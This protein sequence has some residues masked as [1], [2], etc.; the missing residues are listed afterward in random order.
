[1]RVLVTGSSGFVGRH[2]AAELRARGHAVEG[3]SRRAAPPVDLLAAAPLPDPPPGGWAAAFH[4]AAHA[5]PGREWT[6]A[7]ARENALMARRLLEHLAERSPATRAVVLSSAHVYA[8]SRAPH[9]E[10]EPLAPASPYGR[11]KLAV[12]ELARAHAARGLPAL[13]VRPFNLLGPGMPAGL[14]VP[15]LLERLRSGEPVL[16]MRGRD[17]VRDLL[18]VRDGARALAGLAEVEDAPATPLNLCSGAGTRVSELARALLR[19]LGERREL[20]FADPTEDVLIGRPDRLRAL[21]GWRPRCELGET[22]EW[23]AAAGRPWTLR[24]RP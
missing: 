12:E 8:P 5:V 2:L 4:L 24:P 1:M 21:L 14:L 6:D 10:L 3:W 17:A 9:D 18:D 23:I 13:V 7:H 19:A 16:R 22:A 11:S 15:D 20:A